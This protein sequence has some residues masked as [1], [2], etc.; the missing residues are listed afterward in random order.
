MLIRTSAAALAVF[1]AS[2]AI[3]NPGV[4]YNDALNDIS[5]NLT[6]GNGT[7]DL[8][9]MEVSNTATDLV[10]SLRVNGDLTGAS[11]TDWG[12]FMIDIATGTISGDSL[13]VFL[14]RRRHH[15]R[16]EDG[17]EHDAGDALHRAQHA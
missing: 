6:S 11:A 12:K 17:G 13:L 7:L 15:A 5:N 4:V 8:V 16:Q 2:G 10:F 9:S 14:R 3:A 1:V